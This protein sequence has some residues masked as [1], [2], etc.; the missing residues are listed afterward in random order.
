MAQGTAQQMGS[1]LTPSAPALS[2]QVLATPATRMTPLA[3]GIARSGE[4]GAERADARTDTAAGSYFHSG[5]IRWHVQTRGQG[6]RLLLL[7]GTGSASGSWNRLSAA[8]GAGFE[9]LAPDL[10]GHGLSGAMPRSCSGLDAY[11]AAVTALVTD[12]GAWPDIIVGHSAGAAIAARIALHPDAARVAVLSINGA[13]RPLH[14]WTAATYVPLAKLLG[15]N[16]LVPGFVA[17]LVRADTRSVRR[18]LDATGSRIDAGMV[19]QY[20]QLMR[21][22]DHIAGTLR[23]LANW[24]LRALLP[25]LPR[26]GPR[27]TLVAGGADRT[28]APQDADWVQAR[29]PGSTRISLPALGH[30]AH[31]EAPLDIARIVIA[32][33]RDRGLLD[34][35]PLAAA[36]PERCT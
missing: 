34:D 33:A 8:L 27:L 7:H 24:D 11:A 14:G 35:A 12:M 16:P 19:A 1:T 21:N 29:V 4:R 13:L 31:E 25:Q 17:S 18:L 3:T 36:T 15:L 5:A 28:I 32:V 2:A 10:P 30:L 9:I 22:P 26:L 6:P 23:M 20:E